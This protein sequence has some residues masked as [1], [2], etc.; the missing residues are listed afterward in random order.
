MGLRSLPLSPRCAPRPQ[1]LR[2]A[3]VVRYSN[4]AAHYRLTVANAENWSTTNRSSDIIGLPAGRENSMARKRRAETRYV[5]CRAGDGYSVEDRKIGRR[6]GYHLSPKIRRFKRDSVL[7]RAY[8]SVCGPGACV[9]RDR[10]PASLPLYR[11]P[12]PLTPRRPLGC[13]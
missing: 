4:A 7:G 12:P 8:W 13:S 6:L 5:I 10:C 11:I 3:A 1:R 9:G 2:R